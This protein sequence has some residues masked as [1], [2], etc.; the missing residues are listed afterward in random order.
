MTEQGQYIQYTRSNPFSEKKPFDLSLHAAHKFCFT[1]YSPMVN[2]GLIMSKNT[3]FSAQNLQLFTPKLD[4]WRLNVFAIIAVIV[5]VTAISIQ[6]AVYRS[7]KSLGARHINQMII[8]SLV[9]VFSLAH[10]CEPLN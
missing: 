9:S 7:L 1:L 3:T 5:A 4:G 6:S 8:P 2:S 10:K